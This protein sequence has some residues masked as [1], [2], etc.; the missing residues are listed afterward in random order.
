MNDM[1]RRALHQAMTILQKDCRVAN[2]ACLMV[3]LHWMVVLLM[4]RHYEEHLVEYPCSNRCTPVRCRVFLSGNVGISYE[5]FLLLIV[6][7]NHN[8][9]M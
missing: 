5:L 2:P 4:P 9:L 8:N 3:L 1:P 7:K 6:G